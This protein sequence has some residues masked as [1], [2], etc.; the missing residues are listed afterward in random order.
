[1]GLF[2]ELLLV[3][4]LLVAGRQLDALESALDLSLEPVDLLLVRGSHLVGVY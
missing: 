1:M 3:D 2:F 4:T